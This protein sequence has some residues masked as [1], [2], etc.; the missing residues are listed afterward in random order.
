MQRRI[1][2]SVQVLFSVGITFDRSSLLCALDQ[3][4]QRRIAPQGARDQDDAAISGRRREQLLDGGRNGFRANFGEN[5]A[6]SAK[7]RNG[8]GFVQQSQRIGRDG[9]AAHFDALKRI[10]PVVDAVFDEAKGAL[11]R[12][13]RRRRRG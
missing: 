12:R 4:A 2:Q 8:I 9:V 5:G 13:G 6:P 3:F 7:E 1:D 11:A 10:A